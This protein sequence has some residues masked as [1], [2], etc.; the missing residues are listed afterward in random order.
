MT[1]DEIIY[2]DTTNYGLPELPIVL[3]NKTNIHDLYYRYLGKPASN[4]TFESLEELEEELKTSIEHKLYKRRKEY[5]KNNLNDEMYHYI[6]NRYIFDLYYHPSSKKLEKYYFLEKQLSKDKSILK[7]NEDIESSSDFKYLEECRTHFYSLCPIQEKPQKISKIKYYGPVGITGYAKVCRE[8]C[9][10]LKDDIDFECIQFQN[11]DMK[12][13]H[14]ELSSLVYKGVDRVYDYIIL[15]STPDLWPNIC[16][17]ERDINKN[18]IIY[19][20]SAWETDDIPIEWVPYINYVDKISTPSEFSSNAF[21][22]YF[23]GVVDTVYHPISCPKQ[24]DNICKLSKLT[25]KYDY[26]F[27]NVSEW[28]N[29]KGISKLIEVYLQTFDKENVL[30]YIKTHG[31]ISQD[32]GNYFISTVRNRTK[33]TANIILDY[34]RVS[35]EYIEC[36]NN[37]ADCYVS[38]AKSEGHGIGICQAVLAGKHAITTNYSAPIEYLKNIESVD[39]IRYELEPATYCTIWSKK[40]QKCKDL[41]H[42]ANFSG[43]IPSIHRWANINKQECGEKMKEAYINKKKGIR[44][45]EG[46]FKNFKEC[47]YKSLLST[48]KSDRSD[49]LSEQI[50]SYIPQRDIFNYSKKKLVLLNCENKDKVELSLYNYVLS[51]FFED[52][53][54]QIIPELFILKNNDELIRTNEFE[55]GKIIL[56]DFDFMIIVGKLQPSIQTIKIYVEYCQSNKKPYALL[57]FG[58]NESNND[59]EYNSQIIYNKYK[60]IIENS[61]YVSSSQIEDYYIIKSNID[62]G[63]KHILNYYPNIIYSLS[64]NDKVLDKNYLVCV[65]SDFISIKWS[66]ILNYIIQQKESKNLSIIFMN[67]TSHGFWVLKEKKLVNTYFPQALFYEGLN[68]D[69]NMTTIFDILSKTSILISNNYYSKILTKIFNIPTL[70]DFDSK[71]VYE[72]NGEINSSIKQLNTIHYYLYNNFIPTYTKWNE[73]DRNRHIIE[74]QK[75][76]EIDISFIQHFNNN[77]LEEVYNRLV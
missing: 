61:C 10:I 13:Y 54:L 69:Y 77:K 44:I 6:F 30:L 18:V 38:C 31:D 75:R 42:C 19:G 49:F 39:F 64:Y 3:T 56:K 33:S 27:Y 45:E 48:D 41:P 63:F 8:I 12:E 22:K 17:K 51:Y 36:I 46:L 32:E 9:S 2:F 74:I 40:H 25:R 52:F 16:K 65:I 35:D 71:V 28:T 47:F 58:F 66:H 43:F 11:Y 53:E 68:K 14:K 67:W 1:T 70:I 34:D 50:I 72:S 55:K 73:D 15:H 5:F 76:T 26:I 23:N 37:C 20:I 21:R 57:S 62:K 59:C 24:L 4:H 60:Y 29:R 7:I